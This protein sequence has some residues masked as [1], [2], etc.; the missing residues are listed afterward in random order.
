MIWAKSIQKKTKRALESIAFHGFVISPTHTNIPCENLCSFIT[1]TKKDRLERKWYGEQNLNGHVDVDGVPN[2]PR[3]TPAG[4]GQRADDVDDRVEDPGDGKR[5]DQLNSQPTAGV[6]QHIEEGNNEERQDVLNVIQV[7]P[8]HSLNIWV[9]KFD[10]C[11]WVHLGILWIGKHQLGH[12]QS[13][14]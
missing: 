9:I 14:C 7:T 1:A 8:S 10:L 11:L 13:S 5:T 6:G 12:P 4:L 3:K 2:H